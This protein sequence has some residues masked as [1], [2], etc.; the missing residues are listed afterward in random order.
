MSGKW[1]VRDRLTGDQTEGMKDKGR[2]QKLRDTLN[3]MNPWPDKHDNAVYEKFIWVRGGRSD[4]K[5]LGPDAKRY[6]V[7]KRRRK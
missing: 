4:W 1:V 3:L 5:C 6:V 7:S 2:A